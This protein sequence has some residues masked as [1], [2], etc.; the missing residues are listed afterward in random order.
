MRFLKLILLFS[1]TVQGGTVSNMGPVSP[2]EALL[3]L[4]SVF[5][6][7]DIQWCKKVLPTLNFSR[8][9]VMKLVDDVPTKKCFP[10]YLY[11]QV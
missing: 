5:Y 1:D 4:I 11:C 6:V 7:F 3:Q 8:A 2:T 10:R 9:I